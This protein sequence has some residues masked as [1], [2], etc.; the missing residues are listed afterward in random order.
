MVSIS[1]GIRTVRRVRDTL[2]VTI[3]SSAAQQ[4]G[5]GPGDRVDVS[6][7]PV[8][9]GSDVDPALRGAMD[10]AWQQLEPGLRYLADR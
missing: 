8:G 1:I 6:L 10:A 3:P 4:L 7:Q 9:H 5:I 2:V